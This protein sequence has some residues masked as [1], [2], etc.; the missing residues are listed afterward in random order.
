[1]HVSMIYSNKYALRHEAANNE[2]RSG[3]MTG[4]DEMAKTAI[5][6]LPSPRVRLSLFL[7][8]VSHFASFPINFYLRST[9]TTSYLDSSRVSSATILSFFVLT[10]SCSRSR[11]ILYRLFAG[12]RKATAYIYFNGIPVRQASCSLRHK[13][14][15]WKRKKFRSY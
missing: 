2:R 5:V 13:N 4:C 8:F 3:R 6:T 9:P 7:F 10:P 12:V 15:N 11:S 14:H 1:M